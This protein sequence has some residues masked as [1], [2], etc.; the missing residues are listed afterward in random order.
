MQKR[1][2]SLYY[3]KNKKNIYRMILYKGPSA[4]F[5]KQKPLGI[6]RIGIKVP[7]NNDLRFRI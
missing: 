6:A 7:N 4:L 2:A 5:K 1:C 3:I